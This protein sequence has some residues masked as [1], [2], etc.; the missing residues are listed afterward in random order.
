MG[1]ALGTVL[2]LAVAI[3]IFPVPIVASVILVGSEGG[4][5]KGLAF[6]VAWCVGLAAM[7]AAVLLVAGG[8][9]ASDEGDPA[10][11]VNVLLLTLGLLLLAAAARQWRG[12]PAAGGEATMPGW[13][14]TLD[15]FTVAKAAGAGFALTVL[16]PKNVALTVAAAA[17]IAVFGLP[18]G[19]QVAVL[20]VFLLIAS[21]GVLTPLVVSVALGAG[22]REPLD[23][24]KAWL[25]GHNAVIMAALFVLIA[26]K[27]IGDAIA[28]F[29]S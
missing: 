23:R 3:A 21:V 27:L 17:E 11:W 14:R 6:V 28:G 5:T 8:A 26:A 15:G 13:M 4:R 24:L 2:P 9:D 25:A 22:S 1:Q 19:Q 29:S 10:T 16:N 20:L 12:R 18:A 7:G